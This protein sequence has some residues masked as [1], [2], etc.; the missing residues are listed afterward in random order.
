M[1]SSKRLSDAMDDHALERVPDSERKTWLT[2]AW[3]SVGLV[4]TLVILFLGA[5]V[6]FVAGVKLALYAG[7]TVLLVG[8]SLAWAIAHI[9][10]TTGC[11]S[12]VLTR[13]YGL[14][15]RGSALA[16]TVFGCMI[17]SFLAIENALLYRGFIF[18]FEAQ[19]TVTLRIIIY[20]LF[21][22]AWISLTAFGFQLVARV[23]SIMVIGFLLVLAWIVVDIVRQSDYEL[24]QLVLFP[25][26]L[27]D[28]ALDGMGIKSDFDK[29]VFSLNIL[30]GPAGAIA[31]NNADFGRY[32][33]ST[34][35][36]GIAGT[37]AVLMQ[38]CIVMVIG[39]ILMFA[40]ASTVMEYFVN[41]KGYSPEAAER[42]V[43]QSP[44][45]IAATFMVF[46]GALGFALM[47]LAQC[48]AQVL[49]TYSSSLSFTNLFD[50][51]FDWR[52]GR[53]FFVILVNIISLLMLY[54]H[55]L[56]FVEAWITFLGV[57]LTCLAGVVIA[58]F[59]IV[60]PRIRAFADTSQE[61]I[62]VAGV[63]TVIGS[64]LLAHY[65]F[66]A[67]IP[68]EFV[69]SLGGALVLYPLLRLTILRPQVATGAS[70]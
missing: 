48:K 51:L 52:P 62:N 35:D 37:L 60:A 54:G 65:V 59:Y 3:N 22:V 33:R 56:E 28:S 58:D 42:A 4:T 50:A 31:L 66:T 44:D 25:T 47:L 27:P 64:T 70:A 23:S 63:V 61:A 5:L 45:T 69:A 46:G 49:N 8:S 26:Q 30:I 13:Q 24:A 68:I 6:C 36:A 55:I 11:S 21:T 2:I 41:V 29:Y 34:A 12:T 9:A 38:S 19:D 32:G 16:S 15:I 43:L 67:F 39:G 40:G 7:I 53:F 18:F 57:F 10:Y 14:G 20:G 17:I 1:S